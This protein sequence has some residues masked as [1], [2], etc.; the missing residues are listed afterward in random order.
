MFSFNDIMPTY[1]GDGLN[2]Q[3]L[4]NGPPP[5]PKHPLDIN[6]NKK[7]IHKLTSFNDVKNDK[8]LTF[9]NKP[10]INNMNNKKYY[11]KDDDKKDDDKKEEDRKPL[12]TRE[13][14]FI[15]IDKIDRI[16]KPM[17]EI[18]EQIESRY[19]P[20]KEV[21]Y[22]VP[23]VENRF[24][25]LGENP[26]QDI[27]RL[28]FLYEDFIPDP[29]LPNKITTI[30][31]RFDLWDFIRLNVMNIFTDGYETDKKFIGHAEKSII[32]ALSDYDNV[33]L[34]KLFSKVKSLKFNPNVLDKTKDIKQGFKIYSSCYPIKKDGN[35]VKCSNMGQIINLRIYHT[36]LSITDC[37][38]K[39]SEGKDVNVKCIINKGDIDMMETHIGREFEF[40]EYIKDAIIVKKETPNLP[41]CYGII[42]NLFDTSIDFNKETILNKIDK[43]EPTSAIDKEF[44]KYSNEFKMYLQFYNTTN[45]DKVDL[46]HFKKALQKHV[47]EYNDLKY[48]YTDKNKL[49][50]HKL[51][52]LY[53]IKDTFKKVLND[54]RYT[55]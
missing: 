32:E 19:L 17:P 53:L 23:R 5:K 18:P 9:E 44:E 42:Q 24:V 6:F 16:N 55:E 43:D 11:K 21:V 8:E 47:E 51:E 29:L 34:A 37:Q 54:F 14:L 12:T 1:G 2:I 22:E 31:D 45:P 26:Y 36:P 4:N 7:D 13:S 49:T 40:Y 25:S 15:P 52:K 35:S 41:I 3:P 28:N 46:S 33:G 38:V 50:K 20:I 27:N 39:N 30:T 10:L 48:Y